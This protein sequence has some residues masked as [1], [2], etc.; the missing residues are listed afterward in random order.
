MNEPVLAAL[1]L[2]KRYR[3]GE[4]DLDVLNGL[5][6]EVAAGESVA[7]VGDSGVG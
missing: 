4:R 1:G 7:I 6:V 5:D 3:S 2:V